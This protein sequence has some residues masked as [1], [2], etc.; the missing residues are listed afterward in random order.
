[1][2]FVAFLVTWN[3]YDDDDDDDASDTI[4]QSRSAHMFFT[5]V[6]TTSRPYLMVRCISRS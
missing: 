6:R 4:N 2:G 5:L 3:K 1:M